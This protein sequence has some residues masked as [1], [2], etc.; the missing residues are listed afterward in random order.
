MDKDE[1]VRH[2]AALTAFGSPAV[3]LAYEQWLNYEIPDEKARS[4][5]EEAIAKELRSPSDL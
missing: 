2:L 1:A 4:S 3:R 5:L